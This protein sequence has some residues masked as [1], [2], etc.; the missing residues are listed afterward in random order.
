MAIGEEK[1]A[2]GRKKE[3]GRVEVH[4]AKCVIEWNQK[5]G[6]LRGLGFDSVV[7]ECKP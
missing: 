3:K 1:L 7:G 5:T 4:P 2:V 6:L